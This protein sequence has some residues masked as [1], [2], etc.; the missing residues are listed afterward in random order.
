MLLGGLWHGASWTFVAWGAYHGTLLAAE[1]ALGKQSFYSRLPRAFRVAFTFTL[2]LISW[3]LFRSATFGDAAG[4]LTV[5]FGGGG[6]SALL[7]ATLYTRETLAVMAACAVLVTQPTQA[8]DWSQEVTW[9][10]ALLVQPLFCVS[11][12]V[13]FA[14]SFNPFLY[15]QF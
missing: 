9:P 2:V 3:V 4:Y 10:K 5:M 1:R 12:L 7:S 15:F 14:Q 8:H 11:L 6:A 13:M